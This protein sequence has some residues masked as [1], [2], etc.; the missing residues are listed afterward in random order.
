[1][2]RWRAL[3]RAI[4]GLRCATLGLRAILPA[5]G[6]GLDMD[7]TRAAPQ[8]QRTARRLDAGPSTVRGA[9][10]PLSLRGYPARGDS[11]LFLAFLRVRSLDLRHPFR[12]GLDTSY[13][14]E[15]RQCRV[16]VAGSPAE[17]AIRPHSYS[18]L[19][20]TSG[21]WSPLQETSRTGPHE[22]LSVSFRN[23]SL[24]ASRILAPRLHRDTA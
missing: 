21:E 10:H 15:A 13:P 7:A 1:M 11:S 19:G 17:L 24:F 2:W 23:I 22:Y 16:S 18:S 9:R 6:R 8:L 3:R 12:P 20:L 5:R 4:L 14:T